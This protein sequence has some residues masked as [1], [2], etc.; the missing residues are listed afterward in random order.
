MCNSSLGT[1]GNKIDIMF[2][3]KHKKTE[4]SCVFMMDLTNGYAANVNDVLIEKKAVL[5][6]TQTT[7][8][9]TARYCK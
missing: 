6:G 2:I 3:I 1:H 7:S 4:Q 9:L 5:Q 8:H